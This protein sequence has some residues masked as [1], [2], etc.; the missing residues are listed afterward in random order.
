MRDFAELEP[1][2]EALCARAASEHPNT[3]LL[4]EIEDLLAEGY[5]CALH[6]DLRSRRLQDRFD[7]LVAAGSGEQLRAVAQEQRLVA[8]ATRRLRRQ[9]ATMRAHWVALGSDRIGLA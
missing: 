6:G 8:D 2:I 9:L 5:L 1:L 4:V 7:T 3:R